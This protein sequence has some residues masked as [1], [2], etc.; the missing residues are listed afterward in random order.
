[1]GSN[2]YDKNMC[3]FGLRISLIRWSIQALLHKTTLLTLVRK[4]LR[5]LFLMKFD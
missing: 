4:D 1:M 2:Q 3:Q 5:I